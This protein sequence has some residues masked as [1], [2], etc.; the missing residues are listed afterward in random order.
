MTCKYAF[1][2]FFW[3]RERHLAVILPVQCYTLFQD[4]ESC[5]FL[6]NCN[7]L[8]SIAIFIYKCKTLSYFQHGGKKITCA[9]YKLFAVLLHKRHMLN[10]IVISFKALQLLVTNPELCHVFKFVKKLAQLEL[11][12]FAVAENYFF[13]VLHHF[14]QDRHK[15]L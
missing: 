6:T 13:R 10:Q 3:D 11:E 7:S 1:M 9:E 8:Q 14:V 5:K 4:N 15:Q 2:P 12:L